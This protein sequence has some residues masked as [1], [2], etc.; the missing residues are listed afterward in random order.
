MQ[1]DTNKSPGLV[2]PGMPVFFSFQRG[3]PGK[4]CHGIVIDR[5]KNI[6]IAVFPTYYY[7]DGKFDQFHPYNRHVFS[8]RRS[9]KLW[10]EVG[11]LHPDPMMASLW[12]PGEELL[13]S[14]YRSVNNTP[15]EYVLE[16]DKLH[17]GW[18]TN[19]FY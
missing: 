6:L 14:L 5:R 11:D 4:L 3:Q 13:K 8:W 15:E 17:P 12:F 18:R 19:V 10:A 7:P 9:R 16:W 2:I 1:L